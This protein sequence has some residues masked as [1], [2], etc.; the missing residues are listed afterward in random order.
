V[1]LFVVVRFLTEN[2]YAVLVTISVAIVQ[3]QLTVEKVAH[4]KILNAYG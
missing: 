4:A 2:F 3:Q 1:R